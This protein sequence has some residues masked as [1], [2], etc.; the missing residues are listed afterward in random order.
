MRKFKIPKA[1]T[2][3]NK[4]IR[5]PDEIIKGVETAIKGT[6]CS[7]SLFVIEAVKVAL[8]SLEDEKKDG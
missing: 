6:D 4:S 7:F 2:S 5:F 3:T 8:E 1:P